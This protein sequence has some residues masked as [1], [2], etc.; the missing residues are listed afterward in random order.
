MTYASYRSVKERLKKMGVRAARDA[1]IAAS[2]QQGPA[3]FYG[4][5]SEASG[6]P[7]NKAVVR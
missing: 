6:M 2:F 7:S 5:A 3:S 4:S 1:A